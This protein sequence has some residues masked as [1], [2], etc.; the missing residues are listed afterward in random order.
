MLKNSNQSQVVKY[1]PHHAKNGRDGAFRLSLL[2]FFRSANDGKDGKNGLPGYHLLVNVSAL[3]IGDSTLLKVA[4]TPDVEKR[5][6]TNY[7]SNSR[8]W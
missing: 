7:T 4:V 1:K 5:R 2:N 6:K 3:S 8:R